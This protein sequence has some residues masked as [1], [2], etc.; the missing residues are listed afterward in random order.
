MSNYVKVE[1]R[2]FTKVSQIEIKLPNADGADFSF[3]LSL[4][5]AQDFHKDLGAAVFA[6]TK[7]RCAVGQWTS[8][9]GYSGQILSCN[10]EAGHI[11]MHNDPVEG[12]WSSP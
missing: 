2:D 12:A 1:R 9:Y 6:P 10:W 4:D 11:G 8:G 7:P 5:E 3:V